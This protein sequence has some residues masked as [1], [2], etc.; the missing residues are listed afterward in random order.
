MEAKGHNDLRSNACSLKLPGE[1]PTVVAEL[2]IGELGIPSF[3]SSCIGLALDV[4]LNYPVAARLNGWLEAGVLE[5]VL[6]LPFAGKVD[7][8]HSD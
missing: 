6:Q 4:L 3:D 8:L 7:I 5:S 1:E 2:C